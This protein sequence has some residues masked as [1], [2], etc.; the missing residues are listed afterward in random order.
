MRW[1]QSIKLRRGGSWLALLGVLVLVAHASLFGVGPVGEDFRTLVEAS[2]GVYPALGGDADAGLA[3][4]FERAGTGGRPLAAWSLGVSSWLW[5]RGGVWTSFA[6][7]GMRLENLLLLAVTAFG[8][9]RLLR[10]LLLPWVDG[11]QAT[12]AA[13]AAF[14]VL[15]VHPLSV[16]AV[17]SPAARGDLIAAALAMFAGAAF[18]KGRQDRHSGWVA[19]A[20]LVTAVAT[21]ASELGYLVPIWLALIEGTS[22][23]RHRRGHVRVRTALT[24]LIVF[25]AFAGTDVLLRLGLGLDPWPAG[26]HDSLDALSGL[27]GG[28][29]AVLGGLTRLGVLILPVNGPNAGA[30]GFVFGALILVAVIQ[31]ALQAGLSAPRFWITWL[32]VWLGLVLLALCVRAT[33]HVAPDDFSAAAGL[34]PAVI[35]MA[36]GLGVA[37]TAVS[38]SRREVLPLVVAFLLCALA[39]S[40][41]RGW[42]A[43]AKDAREFQQE[44]VEEVER[45][46]PE[47]RFL[48]VEPPG[49]VDLHYAL[50]LELGWVFDRASSGRELTA[51]ALRMRGLEEGALLALARLEDFDDQRAQGLALVLANRR[52]NP[53]GVQR[54]VAQRLEAPG[55]LGPVLEWRN[56]TGAEEATGAP[57]EGGHWLGPEG[58]RPFAADSAAVEW[59]TVRAQSTEEAPSLAEIYWRARG[60][61][62]QGGKLSGLWSAEGEQAVFDT[63]SSLAWLLGPRVD[64]LLLM[65]DLAEAERAEVWASPPDLGEGLE[66]AVDGDDW[67]LGRPEPALLDAFTPPATGEALES[68]QPWTLVL[69]DL[70]TYAHAEIPCELDEDDGL[71]APDAEERAQE[72]RRSPGSLAW[73]L[74]L[75]V[76]GAVVGRRSGRL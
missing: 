60:S 22:A 65:G 34:F 45:L 29:Y 40:N 32:V 35:V 3:G 31:P 47:L 9:A 55:S 42:R 64:G 70:E 26:L 63:G 8:L 54:W 48:A 2:R 68:A 16:S 23:R 5:T 24:T 41:A 21:Q 13:T 49:L 74:E 14:V 33:L 76:G 37:S 53:E 56:P 7:S 27:S 57:S 46:G 38:G 17:A 67:H 61:V 73:A 28:F 66:P 4:L 10:R 12:A 58:E 52:V 43:A 75:R 19:L 71:V 72:L 50:P 1:K 51:E 69:L 30:F 11:V 20:A 44:V 39:R 59:I 36:V 62:H 18:L 15:L 25:G 6:A